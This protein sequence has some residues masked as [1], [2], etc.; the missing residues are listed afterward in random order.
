M[1]KFELP[2]EKFTKYLFN[3]D[4]P[5][6]G[7]K[8][9]AFIDILGIAPADWRLADQIERAMDDAPLYRIKDGKWGHKLWR[10]SVD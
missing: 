2:Q 3:L 9:K 4:H 6:G 1:A 7:G 5:E 10:P 8:A